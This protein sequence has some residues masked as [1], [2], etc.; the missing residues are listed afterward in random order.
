MSNQYPDWEWVQDETD[1]PQI[2]H[3][4]SKCRQG[5]ISNFQ[6]KS[7]KTGK[8]YHGVICDACKAKWTVSDRPT[9]GGG[10]GST[11]PP[12]K[13]DDRWDS[14]ARYIKEEVSPRLDKIDEIYADVKMTRET[15]NNP[16]K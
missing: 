2:G 16:E 10:L 13:Q 9:S 14:L 5:Y 4:C 12:P 7:K 11:P 1:L 3:Q 6:F 8:E 15:L